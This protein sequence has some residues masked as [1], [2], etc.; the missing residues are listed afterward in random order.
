[1]LIIMVSVYLLSAL[2]SGGW[3]E[4]L[5]VLLFTVVALHALRGSLLPKR[6]ARMILVV[7]LAVT[8]I[9][10]TLSVTTTT[11]RGIVS[12]WAGVVLLLAVVVNV[13]RVLSTR[14]VTMQNIYG[15]LSAY[16]MIGV[17]FAAFFSAIDHQSG[18]R[19][20]A[21][22]QP[23]TT[24]TFQYFSFSTLTTLGYGDFTAA[25]N[26]GRAL[27][28]LEALT[29][30]I[31]L[32]TLVAFLVTRYRA[33]GERMAD[34]PPPGGHLVGVTRGEP[35]HADPNLMATDR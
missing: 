20:F 31:I 25:G 14:T 18:G 9:M 23:D 8:A 13:R 16:L 2:T 17:A 15:A 19:F 28:E 22:G 34:Q 21:Q 1:V 5:R 12:V 4:A 32:V 6:T 35:G 29:G 33:P 26:F 24:Q 30:Q 10:L 7:M 11:G 27:A 3:V